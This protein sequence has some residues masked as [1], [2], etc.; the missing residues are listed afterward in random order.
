MTFFDAATAV[1][2]SSS[3]LDYA[4]ATLTEVICATDKAIE[5]DPN[6]AACFVRNLNHYNA[7]LYA[8]DTLL[9]CACRNYSELGKTL[10]KANGRVAI[11]EGQA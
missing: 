4:R 1:E 3:I 11:V 2:Q 5:P 9:E 6:E 8:V 7:L 10:Y